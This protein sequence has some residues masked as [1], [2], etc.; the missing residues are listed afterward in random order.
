VF[1]YLVDGELGNVKHLKL[2]HIDGKKSM[3]LA[4]DCEPCLFGWQ[5]IPDDARQVTIAEGE[6]DAMSLWQYC[7]PALSV[8]N[9][10]GSHTW[11]EQEYE[12]LQRFDEIFICF[13]GDDAGRKGAAQVIERLGRERCRLVT[14]PHKDANECL[15][16]GVTREA[17][18]RGF[19]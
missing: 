13:D 14:L 9:G 4:K 2:E 11:I 18:G 5:A 3:R 12:R 6:L 16:L 15:Q 8:C 7:R 19:A 1:P 10:A 17:I